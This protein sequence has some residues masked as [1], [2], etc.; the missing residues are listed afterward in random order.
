MG[1]LANAVPFDPASGWDEAKGKWMDAYHRQLAAERPAAPPTVAMRCTC[2]YMI[3]GDTCNAGG[4]ACV[5][6]EHLPGCSLPAGH[7]GPHSWATDRT[8]ADRH[9]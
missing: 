9:G 4:F 5:G 1:L 6:P 7:N 2:G 8:A 3:P